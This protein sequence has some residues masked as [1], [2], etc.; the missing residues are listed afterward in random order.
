[1]IVV[2]RV[3]VLDA[4]THQGALD[5]G[6]VM[7]PT[8]GR[9]LRIMDPDDGQAAVPETLVEVDPAPEVVSRW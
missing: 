3:R 1:V 8:A 5:I 6:L 7:L 4:V 2:L 9:E